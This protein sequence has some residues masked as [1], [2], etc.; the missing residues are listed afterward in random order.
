MKIAYVEK[1]RLSNDNK[2]KLDTINLI[3]DE[4]AEDGYT[5][6]LRQ[7][8]YQLVSRS[9]RIHQHSVLPNVSRFCCAANMLSESEVRDPSETSASVAIA[10]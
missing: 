3:I 6:T 4:Y 9:F 8:Y 7:L 5:L 2:E 1:L 10:C